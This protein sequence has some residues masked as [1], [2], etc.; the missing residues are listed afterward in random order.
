MFLWNTGNRAPQATEPVG[1]SSVPEKPLLRMKGY[2]PMSIPRRAMQLCLALAASSILL[3]VPSPAHA[4]NKGDISLGY[5]RTGNNTFYSGTGGLNGWDLDGQVH[6]KPFIGVEGDVSHYGLGADSGVPRT[7]AVLFGPKLSVG[8]AG[9]RFFGHFLIGGEHS[10]NSSATIPIS[11]GSFAYALGA[12]ADVP[13][14]PF[15]AWRV[16]VDRFTA[17]LIA[18]AHG[19]PVR[20]TTGVVFR[21]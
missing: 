4:A 1:L 18:P 5:S 2:A 10:A 16:Q 7:T 20:F 8:A 12:G 15:F 14:A 6:W 11:H 9:F 21:F 13:M 17:P 3:G 19:T